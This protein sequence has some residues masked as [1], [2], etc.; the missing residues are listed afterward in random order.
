MI[1]AA[2]QYQKEAS[3]YQVGNMV[4]VTGNYSTQQPFNQ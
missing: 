4:Y 3:E 1:T 2:N